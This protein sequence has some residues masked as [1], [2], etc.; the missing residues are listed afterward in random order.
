MGSSTGGSEDQRRTPAPTL[1]LPPTLTQV[2]LPSSWTKP[3]PK[4]AQGVRLTLKL[5][6]SGVFCSTRGGGGADL[7]GSAAVVTGSATAKAISNH[8]IGLL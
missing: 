7:R 5:R 3:G 2:E 4:S 1:M 6:G 8:L